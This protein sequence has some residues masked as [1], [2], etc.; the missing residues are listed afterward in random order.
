MISLFKALS[1][2]LKPSKLVTL[3]MSLQCKVPLFRKSNLIKSCTTS[4][5]VKNKEL[6][7]LVVERE[8]AKKDIL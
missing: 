2:E 6:K 7:L 4:N 8:L 1:K 3:W 5:K